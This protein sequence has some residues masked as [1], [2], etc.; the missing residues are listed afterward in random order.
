MDFM[1]VTPGLAMHPGPRQGA[2]NC[3]HVP[4]SIQV[5]E[6]KGIEAQCFRPA[7][8]LCYVCPLCGVSYPGAEIYVY[9]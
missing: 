6:S 8:R 3:V 4:G 7:C 1:A 5:L 2:V 9:G